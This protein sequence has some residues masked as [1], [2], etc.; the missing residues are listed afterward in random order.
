MKKS[1][2]TRIATQT[3]EQLR[4]FP[5]SDSFAD[6]VL[7]KAIYGLLVTPFGFKKFFPL[8]RWKWNGFSL[9]LKI[10]LTPFSLLW[11]FNL[12][13]RLRQNERKARRTAIILAGLALLSGAVLLCTQKWMRNGRREL[14]DEERGRM[15]DQEIARYEETRA[16]FQ[17]NREKYAF[18]WFQLGW[19]LVVFAL[20]LNV[21]FR[22][23]QPA[24]RARFRAQS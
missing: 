8:R 16:M 11:H 13:L 21:L 10:S 23:F 3:W 2:F 15:S 6:A 14:T 24:T 1:D 9:L 17:Q 20:S 19:W 7:L 4:H 22:A 5:T 12:S 18:T